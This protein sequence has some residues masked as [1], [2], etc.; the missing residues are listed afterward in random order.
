MSAPNKTARNDRRRLT[1][2]FLNTIAAAF[3]IT[4]V[5]VPIISLAYQLT[6]PQTRYWPIF[7]VAWLGF[8]IGLHLI[9][10]HILKGVEE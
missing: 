6:T 8:G 4:G 10:R 1:A 2:T 3:V 7:G 9:A 5:I